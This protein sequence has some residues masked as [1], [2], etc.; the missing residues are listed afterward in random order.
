MSLEDASSTPGA[1]DSPPSIDDTPASTR[2]RTPLW[3]FL[4]L[5]LA[6]GWTVLLRV[7]LVINAGAH[8][9]S[10]VSVDGIT[11]IEL[12]EGKFRWH[13]PGTPHIGIAPV[14]ASLPQALVFGVGPET[15]ISG[16]V[17]IWMLVVV[18]CFALSWRSDGPIAACG[19]LV[20]LTF[21]STGLIW[22]SGRITGGHLLSVAMHAGIFLGLQLVAA[23]PTLLRAA[24]LGVWAG[25]S[26]W[27][28]QMAI[29]S[30]AAL[31][32]AAGYLWWRRG[33]PISAVRLVVA[34]VIGLP[35]GLAPRIIGNRVDPYDA[36]GEQFTAIWDERELQRHTRLLIMDCL[37]R[38]VAGHRIPS[39]LADPSPSMIPS[40]PI[41]PVERDRRGT[42]DE[43]PAH[44][45][46]ILFVAA[47][48]CVLDLRGSP[49]AGAVRIGLLAAC[50]ATAATFIINRNIF[51]S[52]NYR[53][54]VFFI[55]PW[56]LGSGRALERLGRL[57][58]GGAG[59]AML[60]VAVFAGVMTV[61]ARNWYARYGWVDGWKP[62]VAKVE[63]D[64]LEWLE[65]HP[66][67]DAIVGNYWEVYLHTF[68]TGGRVKGVPFAVYPNRF[69]EWSA[70]WPGS[71]PQYIFV[72]FGRS[73]EGRSYRAAAERD[74][75]AAVFQ[76]R[77]IWIVHWPGDK[78]IPVTP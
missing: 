9:D 18:A 67:V 59:L 19:A 73:F 76:G 40:S 43:V 31:V 12:L 20:P 48:L 70:Y 56:A 57:G 45:A 46:A 55:V 26:L 66:E 28:D 7:P 36:Y 61:D 24:A 35:I 77:R 8:L 75:G 63:R 29:V 54:L 69:P 17:V 13:Y 10:D 1:A 30:L 14:L 5:L 41:Q 44:L 65:Q 32:P 72:A 16:G 2:A 71:R 23:R 42:F 39:L 64:E 60:S 33:R 51:N 58:S 11:L 6:L 78:E 49:E 68:L 21:A 38:L 74:G 22:L 3:P 15:L 53:Y 50:A 27:V 25:L 62:V 52:D 4:C 34:F 37:P 47:M